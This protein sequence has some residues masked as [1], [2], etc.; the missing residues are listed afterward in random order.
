[1]NELQQRVLSYLEQDEL[2]EML[3]DLVNIDS[4]TGY[5]KEAGDYLASR[6]DDL[7]LKVRQQSVEDGRDNVMG[8]W[9]GKP[10][11]PSLMFLGHLDT[12]PGIGRAE[13]KIVDGWVTGKGAANMKSAF[14]CYYMATKMLQRAGVDIEGELIIAGVCGEIERAP[15]GAHQGQAH[16]GGGF[17]ARYLVTHG[18]LA[19]VVINGE[20]TS[21]RVQIANGGYMYLRLTTRGL[22][23]H[24]AYKQYGVDAIGKM[25][26]VMAAVNEWE[27][28]YQQHYR[29]PFITPRVS[30]G[31]IEGGNPTSPAL[32]AD[33]C[34]L[35][36]D[37]TLLPGANLQQIKRDFTAMLRRLSADDPQLEVEVEVFMTSNG[38]EIGEDEYVVQAMRRAHIEVNGEE[39]AGID[40]FRCNVSSDNSPLFEYGIRG[41]TYGPA[42][43]S[44]ERPGIYAV[45]D[46][47][48]GEA[49]PIDGM[50][51]CTQAY[52]LAAL[53][54]LTHPRD[55]VVGTWTRSRKR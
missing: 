29:H 6:L 15:I 4:P 8:V 1:M 19:D 48:Y 24:A 49:A 10:E 21:H 3:V 18:G 52:A 38:Y 20:P 32:V 54:I 22:S 5:E 26:T 35:Y 33:S 25:V 37:I 51:R 40:E 28:W 9:E 36:V 50:V 17:G 47:E 34:H 23:Q 46:S 31:A 42:G 7:G 11:G 43:M 44:R 41:I 27:A 2:V 12:A 14:P 39:P 16:R 13:A 53:D 45:Y 30:V 55:E